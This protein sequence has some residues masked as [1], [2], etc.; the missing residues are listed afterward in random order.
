MY[1]KDV[2]TSQGISLRRYVGTKSELANAT[3]NPDNIGFCTPRTKCLPTG[4]LNIS[5]CQTGGSQ[6]SFLSWHLKQY[7][8]DRYSR[9]AERTWFGGGVFFEGVGG[10][11][12]IWQKAHAFY[13]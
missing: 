9:W 7:F 12:A 8:V 2:K 1:Q 13:L 11:G 5:N 10:V 6:T 3:V 4:L